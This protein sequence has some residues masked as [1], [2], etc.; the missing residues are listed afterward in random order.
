LTWDSAIIISLVI[1]WDTGIADEHLWRAEHPA[2][3]LEQLLDV[4][5][6]CRLH[7]TFQVSG[8]SRHFET[9]ARRKAMYQRRRH[10][11]QMHTTNYMPFIREKDGLLNKILSQ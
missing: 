4:A 10:L 8:G 11:S 6:A 3:R 7:R 9:G 2:E 1:S 5:L